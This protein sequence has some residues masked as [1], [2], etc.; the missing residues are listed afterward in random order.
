MATAIWCSTEWGRKPAARSNELWVALAEKAY[1]QV[2]EC[3][4]IRPSSWGGGQNVYT[5]ISGGSMAQALNQITG[6][7]TVSYATAG[8]ASFHFHGV[9]FRIQLGKSVCLGSNS[10]PVS[11]QIVGGH[12]YAV[13]GI[14]TTTKTVTVFNPWG[15]NNGHDSGTI[16]LS[17]TEIQANFGWYDRTA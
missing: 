7:S 15:L 4:W 9:C 11:S 17:W 3:G 16:T 14:N 6:Q 12:A 5:G 13:V 10:N 2:N 8:S 1:V